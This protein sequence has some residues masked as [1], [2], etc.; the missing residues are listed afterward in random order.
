[1]TR[2]E[3]LFSLFGL[4]LGFI[5]IEVLSG[6]VR[7]IRARYP[8]GPGQVAEMRIGWLTPLLGAFVLL[9]ITGWWGNVWSVHASLPLGYDTM[10]GGVILCGI[11]Y[12]A[13]S[14]VFP[15]E[16]RSWPDLDSWFWLHRR[17]VLG[18]ILAANLAWTPIVLSSGDF[19]PSLPQIL[20]VLVY[21]AMLGAS[22]WTSRR[23]LLTAALGFLIVQNLAL[24]V[25]DFISRNGGA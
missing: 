7:T 1:V 23:W 17:L 15:D 8:T 6:L 2:F 13:A 21:F 25:I 16:P 22:I 18:C 9:D 14:L 20:I 4:L 19:K 12:F 10:F 3:F 11:Y 5:L 24:A